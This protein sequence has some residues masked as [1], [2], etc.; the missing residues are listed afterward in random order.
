MGKALFDHI[1][2]E[3]ADDKET[4]LLLAGDISTGVTAMPF[5]EEMCKHF[6]HVLMVHGNHEYYH[7]R[8]EKTIDDWKNWELEGAPKNFHFLYND[9]RILDG[10]RFLGG[11]M[12]TNFNSGN[13]VVI[14]LAHS[15]MSD[16]REIRSVTGQ[17]TPHFIMR[18]NDKFMDFLIQ[19]FDEP[20]DGPTVVMTHHSPGNVQRSGYGQNI[21]NYAYFAEL[22]NMIGNYNKAELWIHGHTHKSADYMINETRVV[23]NPYGYWGYDT[24][25][26]FDRHLILE[27]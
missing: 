14:S 2:N 27:V 25:P 4:T 12:W 23:C 7:N 8:F 11:T 1:H 16:Y 18:E 20:F 24:N 26:E 17:I 21:I 15:G 19:K 10:V 13:P 6:K 9:Y 3:H 5:V 22:E